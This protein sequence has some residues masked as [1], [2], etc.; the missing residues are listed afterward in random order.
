MGAGIHLLCLQRFP[1]LELHAY[2][3]T[4]KKKEAPGWSLTWAWRAA[5]AAA[6]A[7]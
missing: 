6:A 3:K 1:V 7:G 5:A 4:T 2:G